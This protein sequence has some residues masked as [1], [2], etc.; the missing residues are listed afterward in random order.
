VPRGSRRYPRLWLVEATDV[1]A[2]TETVTTAIGASSIVSPLA[3]RSGDPSSDRFRVAFENAPIGVALVSTDGRWL[4]VNAALCEMLGYEED[5]LLRL[6]IVDVTHP[7]DRSETIARRKQQ[8]R[9]RSA[10]KR[11]EKRYI[12]SDGQ[13]IW[14]A[15]T[16]TVVRDDHKLPL[17]TV[18]QIEDISERVRT[19]CSLA[20]AEERF[21][22]AFD[23]APIGMALVGCDG[24]FLQTNR[25]LSGI[26]GYSEHELLRRTFADITHP[27]DLDADVEQARRLLS[28]ETEAYQMEKRYVCADGSVVW[29][30]LSVSL[31]RDAGGKS[32]YFVAQIED[33]NERK[34]ADQELRFLA[35]HDPLTGLLNR[36]RFYEEVDRE[37]ARLARHPDRHA[38]VLL[39]DIDRFKTI[40][41]A[42]GHKAGDEVLTALAAILGLRLRAGDCV[43]RLGGD[44]VAALL[45][46][47]N[48]HDDGVAVARELRDTI[49][50]EPFLTSAGPVAVTVSIGVAAL[51]ADNDTLTDHAL[52]LA[53]DAMYQAKR[54]GRDQIGIAA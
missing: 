22:R 45:V 43:G 31:V 30:A 42:L 2:V 40:N 34:L 20:E 13:T 21:R 33:I 6:S 23:D 44:E 54:N 41:D 48:H 17:Y 38:A 51:G 19:Q 26:T 1:T 32:M 12:R 53:D 11:I 29:V 27:D 35:D 50:A 3:D 14:V 5:E 39:L 25:T 15:V 36:R 10:D 28:G 47:L 9:G 7:A 24:R 16:S 4:H 46:D 18:A 8:L 37:L 49:R 52:T